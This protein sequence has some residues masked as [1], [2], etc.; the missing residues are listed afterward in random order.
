MTSTP[1]IFVFDYHGAPNCNDLRQSAISLGS[2]TDA[3]VMAHDL[4]DLA[5]AV[6]AFNQDTISCVALFSSA[7][8]AV[9]GKCRG[10]FEFIRFLRDPIP[11]RTLVERP[12][13]NVDIVDTM[14][15]ILRPS[16]QGDSASML[17]AWLR[18]TSADNRAAIDEVLDIRTRR[19]SSR[20][21]PRYLAL[22]EQRDAIGLALDIA[23]LDR[24][25]LLGAASVAGAAHDFVSCMPP[26]ESKM[27]GRYNEAMILEHDMSIFGD[28]RESKPQLVS[29]RVFEDRAAKATLVCVNNS[30]IERLAGVD[31]IYHLE[32]YNSFVMVQYKR[33]AADGYR[34][35]ARCE[36]QIAQ[37][38]AV[39]R[40]HFA[41]PTSE[42]PDEDVPIDAE[43]AF[44]LCGNPFFLKI[45]EPG[46]PIE[47]SESLIE[48]MCFPLEHWQILRHRT[49]MPIS[50]K[51]APRWLNN[52]EF[53]DVTRKGWV[54]SRGADGRRWVSEVVRDSL[55]H[56]HALILARLAH[57]ERA[58]S[59]LAQG[60]G[61]RGGLFH[62]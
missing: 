12:E 2:F 56:A 7:S 31:L 19:L 42:G 5:I 27:G 1:A 55:S 52:T 57:D 17:V 10:K 26:S 30:P 14:K 8:R 24:P 49:G 38:D 53:I 32:R 18:E 3:L 59:P 11:I 16:A 21:D 41:S 62:A 40:R 35:D 58:R 33:A 45:C 48:G 4:A 47:H 28:W 39:F 9:T 34:P 51:N 15:R 43:R 61:L 29:T 44:R 60:F 13:K 25:R 20:S 6:I 23:G 54:G 36:R 46:G 22:S 37:M 50:K